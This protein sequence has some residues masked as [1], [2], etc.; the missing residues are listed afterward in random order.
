MR[1]LMVGTFLT[2]DGV[3][4]GPGGPEEDR[5]GGFAHGGWLEE[6]VM[7]SRVVGL[8]VAGI[9]FGLIAVAQVVR[10]LLRADVLV[11]G[12]HLP[13]WPSALA[14]VI[15][16]GLCLAAQAFRGFDERGVGAQAGIVL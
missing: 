2:L 11:N 16:G 13:L 4:Q 12:H 15:L 1:K 14:A 7:R 6:P 10:L 3:L 9:M 5:S 8:R